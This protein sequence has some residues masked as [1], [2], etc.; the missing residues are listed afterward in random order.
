MHAVELERMNLCDLETT[1]QELNLE[2][3]VANCERKLKV[4][5]I[6]TTF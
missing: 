1:P 2:N 5:S 4:G 6:H 3:G